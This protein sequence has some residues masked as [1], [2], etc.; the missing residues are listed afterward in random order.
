MRS[1]ALSQATTEAT[2]RYTF[3]IRPKWLSFIG[4]PIGRWYLGRDIDRRI[5]GYAKGCQD[6]VVLGSLESTS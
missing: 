5:A 3:S 2:W 4:D 6:E 1:C